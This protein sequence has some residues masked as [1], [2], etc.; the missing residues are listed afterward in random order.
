MVVMMMAV[1]VLVAIVVI[2]I[3][4]V[5][6]ATRRLPGQLPVQV[7]RDQRFN[8]LIRRPGYHADALLSKERQRSL[9]DAPSDD[10]LNPKAVKPPRKRA[11]LMFGCRQRFGMQNG[12]GVGIHF[13]NGEF[14]AAAEVAIKT[15]VLNRNGN[16]HSFVCFVIF[17]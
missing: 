7:G 12:F 16:F 1:A 3:V 14:A 17:H 10:K 13:H 8:R 2:M 15:S 5:V 9:A 6:R 4:P 11:R